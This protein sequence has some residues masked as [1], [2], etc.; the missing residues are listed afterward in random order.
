VYGPL[1]LRATP[2]LRHTDWIVLTIQIRAPCRADMDRVGWLW[3]RKG[4][5][6]YPRAKD[7]REPQLEVMR[8]RAA[9]AWEGRAVRTIG[10]A[11][12]EGLGVF[13]GVWKEGELA[14]LS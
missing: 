14:N 5:L 7:C 13:L 12:G 8:T 3:G 9:F 10:V 1:R 2:Q 11:L 6:E 4:L